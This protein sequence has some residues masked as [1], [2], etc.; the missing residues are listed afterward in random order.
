M[1]GEYGEPVDRLTQK[2]GHCTNT[3]GQWNVPVSEGRT[4]KQLAHETKVWTAKMVKNKKKN[5]TKK[6]KKAK[7]KD[8]ET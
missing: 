4:Q 1:R 2:I 8:Q 7:R 5:E 3:T 6:M